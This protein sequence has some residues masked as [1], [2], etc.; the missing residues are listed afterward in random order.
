MTSLSR[1]ALAARR[2]TTLIFAFFFALLVPAHAATIVVN[3]SDDTIHADNCTLRAAIASINGASLQGACANTGAAFGSGDVINF[4]PSVT[5]ITLNDAPNNSLVI[6]VADLVISG[7][8]VIERNTASANAFRL[9]RHNVPGTFSLIGVTLRGGLVTGTDGGAAVR[10]AGTVSLQNATVQNN[11]TNCASCPGGAVFA[12][13]GVQTVNS[14]FSGNQT[15]S[16]PGSPGGAIFSN[17]AIELSNSVFDRNIAESG[18]CGG[19]VAATSGPSPSLR[20]ISSYFESNEARGTLTTG[21]LGG[22][23]CASI[24]TT[25]I[26]NSEFRGNLSFGEG[27]ALYALGPV[28]IDQSSFSGNQATRGG[29]AIRF[30]N[31]ATPHQVR[32]STFHNNSAGVSTT[33]SGNGGAFLTTNDLTLANVTMSNNRSAG[34]GGAILHNGGTLTM[35]STIIANS[36]SE[37]PAN[38]AGN[39]DIY[40]NSGTATIAGSNNLIRAVTSIT[41]PAGTLTSDPQLGALGNQG[42]LA[43]AG[44]GSSLTCPFAQ[45]PA[46]TSPVIDAGANPLAL[47][48]DQRGNGFPRVIGAAADIGAVERGGAAVATWPVNVSI[49]PITNAGNVSCTPNPVPNGQSTTCTATPRPGYVFDGFSGAC[50]GATCVLNNVTAAQNV[51]ARFS[52]IV[53]S[54]TAAAVPTMNAMVL[55]TL[56]IALAGVG[57]AMARRLR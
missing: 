53:V 28:E 21:Q 26:I 49:L 25:T 36:I 27:G 12:P 50:M 9:F 46:L 10:S 18:S 19:A 3:G 39:I 51:T 40:R 56:L 57:G 14:T 15:R 45:L 20:V 41:V 22:A 24:A 37:N 55:V 47:Q 17:G 6:Q 31:S 8:V 1:C 44:T 16:G 32:N 30:A 38:G 42:C 35:T 2:Q 33:N 5:T 23:L 4:A 52:A 11:I 48:Y 43:P 13:V 54:T 29:G 7:N 34:L